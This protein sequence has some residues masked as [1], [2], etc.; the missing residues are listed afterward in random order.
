[1]SVNFRAI[2]FILVSKACAARSVRSSAVVLVVAVLLSI[3]AKHVGSTL[4]EE[5]PN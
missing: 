5:G 1:M 4:R 2:F 3:N